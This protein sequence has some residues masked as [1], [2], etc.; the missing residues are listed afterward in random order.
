MN[1]STRPP[2]GLSASMHA[3]TAAVP[4]GDPCLLFANISGICFNTES[5]LALLS[6]ND[7][8]I[9]AGNGCEQNKTSV[10]RIARKERNRNR[11]TKYKHEI[12]INTHRIRFISVWH[13]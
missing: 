4:T 1:A 13:D 8:A 11:N 9:P 6:S 10:S 7:T 2:W 12:Q 3:L 5:M